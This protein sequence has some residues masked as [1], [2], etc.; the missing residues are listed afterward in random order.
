MPQEDAITVCDSERFCYADSD[1]VSMATSMMPYGK[2]PDRAL[3]GNAKR[4][5]RP[6]QRSQHCKKHK[7][8]G[9]TRLAST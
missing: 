2:V 4:K 7:W 6:C 3:A 9:R 8:P 5:A 1:W